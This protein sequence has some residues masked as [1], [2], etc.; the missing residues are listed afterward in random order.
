M[1]IKNSMRNDRLGVFEVERGAIR[2]HSVFG[3]ITV[4]GGG[5]GGGGGGVG[6]VVAVVVVVQGGGGGGGGGAM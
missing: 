4:A 6:V 5:G 2:I 3:E 1:I